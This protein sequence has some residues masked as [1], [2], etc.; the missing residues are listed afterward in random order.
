MEIADL[1]RKVR[2]IEIRTRRLSRHQ[3]TGG[4][5][6]AFKG[7]GMSFSEVR[8]YQYGD[9]VRNIDWNVTARTGEPFVKI[10]EEERELHL[11]LFADVSA[12]SFFGT[13]AGLSKNHFIAEICAV[14]A[15]SAGSNHD[16]TGLLM[17]SD[18]PEMYLPP[19]QGRAHNLRIIRELLQVQPAHRATNLE[20]GLIFVRNVLKKRSIC[21]LISDFYS[22]S[23]YEAALGILSRRHECIGIHVWEPAERIL[24]DLGIIQA[25]DPETGR[26]QWTDTARPDVR[27]RYTARFDEHI[28]RTR[29]VFH[30]NGSDFISLRT[31]QDYIA[32][33][34]RLFEQRAHRR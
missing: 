11:L 2:E 5:H 19:A 4:Y 14:L 18:Q 20:Q 30:R 13:G 26:L 17:Y 22:D 16:K 23:D 27:R 10:F 1:I 8:S 6:S 29:N 15:F 32:T 25:L 21:F 31:D 7:R 9:D 34:L 3:F 28:E 12:S 24:P 33:L